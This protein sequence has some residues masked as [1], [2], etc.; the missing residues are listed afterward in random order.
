MSKI[1]LDDTLRSKL[2]GLNECLEICDE[3]GATVGQF[4][5]EKIYQKMLYQ[6]AEAQC[7]HTPEEQEE[8][9][10]QT[11]GRPLAEFWREMGRT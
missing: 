8:L 3:T 1:V 5:P 4:L 10:K 6:I 11:G 7:P 9:R 2:N